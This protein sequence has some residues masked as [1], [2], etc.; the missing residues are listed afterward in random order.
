[1]AHEYAALKRTLA[2]RHADDR[3]AYTEAKNDFITAVLRAARSER[4]TPS[5]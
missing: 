5:S 2:V 4:R 3:L 1:V